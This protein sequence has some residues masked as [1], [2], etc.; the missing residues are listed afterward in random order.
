MSYTTIYGPIEIP[1]GEGEDDLLNNHS[2]IVQIL[3]AGRIGGEGED[4]L[5][6]PTENPPSIDKFEDHI[7][8]KK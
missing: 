6:P 1:C 8:K 3:R 4:R 7:F 5:L 2:I